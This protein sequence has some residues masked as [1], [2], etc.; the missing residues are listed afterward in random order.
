M[1][2][3]DWHWLQKIPHWVSKLQEKFNLVGTWFQKFSLFEKQNSNKSL[4]FLIQKKI[5]YH[6]SRV[7]TVQGTWSVWFRKFWA[8]G[9]SSL[10]ICYYFIFFEEAVWLGLRRQLYTVQCFSWLRLR[11]AL[12]ELGNHLNYLH[13]R[14]SSAKAKYWKIVMHEHTCLTLLASEEENF[15]LH[16]N[17]QQCC[18]NTNRFL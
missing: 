13:S 7:Q 10:R 11:N 18:I 1:K 8:G 17:W 5:N 6:I 14:V 9:V 4:A 3:R 12:F 2:S 15:R 16:L